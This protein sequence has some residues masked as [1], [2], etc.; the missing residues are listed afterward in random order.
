MNKLLVA[1]E[2]HSYTT[3]T[4]AT[5]KGFLTKEWL[6]AV[7]STIRPSTHSA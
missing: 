3:P 4:K 6:P 1:I 7:Q 5:V 2:E